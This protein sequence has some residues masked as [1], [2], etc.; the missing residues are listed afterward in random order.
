MATRQ[1]IG[2]RY[3]PKLMGEWDKNIS[4]ENLVIVTYKG[5]SFTSKQNVPQGVDISDKNYWVNTANFNA[6][7]VTIN[8]D[9]SSVNGEISSINDEITS[10]NGEITSIND[11]ITSINDE[12][13]SINGEITS[14]NGEITS[15][16]DEINSNLGIVIGDSYTT[17]DP[18]SGGVTYTKNLGELLVKNG[19]LT[20]CFSYGV[21]G[22]RYAINSNSN[23][24]SQLESAS[25]DDRFNNDDVKVIIIEGGQNERFESNTDYNRIYNAVKATLDY[26]KSKFVNANIYVLPIG[27]NGVKSNTSS[28]DNIWNPII[29]CA[30][31]N[32]VNASRNSLFFGRGVYYTWGTDN[33][34]PTYDTLKIIA[35]K[36][37]AFINGY[38]NIFNFPLAVSDS[39]GVTILSSSLS[40]DGFAHIKIDIYSTTKSFPANSDLGYIYPQYAT[41][42]NRL[43]TFLG[44]NKDDGTAT[45][46]FY[47]NVDSSNGTG[48]IRCF[49]E[50]PINTRVQCDL[51]YPI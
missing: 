40:N 26:A 4:Y 37:K 24:M 11:E 9:I 14:I 17:H 15:I 23:F 38:E 36:I 41:P 7:L 42:P 6:Q 50:I 10:I 34:H 20:N 5:N 35:N 3:V 48:N 46:G 47:I 27:W 13:T 49:N 25:S 31:D 1:Y 33:T 44:T 18:N 45:A 28:M 19:C 43:Y 2:A 22:A 8:E 51:S 29:N 32:G 21:N 16:K 12:I 30:I 39:D